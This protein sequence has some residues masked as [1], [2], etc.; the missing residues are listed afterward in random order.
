[1][2]QLSFCL[3]LLLGISACKKSD[4]PG[5]GNNNG[6]GGGTSGDTTHINL[7]LTKGEW[8]FIKT[9]PVQ[10][11]GS[12]GHFL[13]EIIWEGKRVQLY[14]GGSSMQLITRVRIENGGAWQDV[15]SAVNGSR[16][17]IATGADGKLYHYY[18]D[19]SGH[20]LETY[21]GTG[22]SWTSLYSG[23]AGSFDDVS[24]H[25]IGSNLYRFL[26]YAD[27]GKFAIDRWNATSWQRK[28]DTTDHPMPDKFRKMTVSA[29][30]ALP[31]TVLISFDLSNTATSTESR[32]FYTFDGSAAALLYVQQQTTAGY[33]SFVTGSR[34]KWYL[35]RAAEGITVHSTLEEITGPSSTKAVTATAPDRAW[36]FGNSDGDR[37]HFVEFRKNAPNNSIEGIVTWDGNRWKRYPHPPVGTVFYN[38]YSYDGLKV[39][40]GKLQYR[41]ATEGTIRVQEFRE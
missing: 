10:T 27:L 21:N 26:L 17:N 38:K 40:D 16:G 39:V 36:Y 4:D 2:K 23:N 11:T 15:F 24:M 30:N 6:G 22:S 37:I 3:L 41:Q 20:H 7:P 14:H 19:G 29:E 28:V 25:R 35:T 31:G 9:E 32:R 12:G 1:M 18:E 8:V 33:P 34:G 13:Q 5:G